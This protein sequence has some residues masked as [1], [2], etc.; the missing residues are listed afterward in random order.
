MHTERIEVVVCPWC[1][2]RDFNFWGYE[3]DIRGFRTVTCSNCGLIYVKNRLTLEQLYIYYSN[4]HSEIHQINDELNRQRT[5]MYQLEYDFVAKYIDGGKV[6][7]VGCGGGYFL[8]LF[9][10]NGYECTGVEL[11]AE[12]CLEAAKKHTVIQGFFNELS[13][14]DNY[15]LIVFR[16]VLEHI[17]NPSD[18]LDKARSLLNQYGL[19]FITSTPDA[20]SLCCEL[21]KDHWNQHIPEEHIMHFKIS[22]F[23][24][25]FSD[26]GMKKH[27]YKGFYRE[28]P[29]ASPADDIK[30]VHQAFEEL[31]NTNKVNA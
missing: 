18:F 15:D 29:Y 26:H 23:D 17:P 4:Y 10:S 3:I 25:Y 21:F 31:K 11:G 2:S 19:I 24:K 27:A 14:D 5:K 6:V 16:G 1:R 8:D 20:G 13:F 28:T 30:R 7:G 9:K 12:A 22:H